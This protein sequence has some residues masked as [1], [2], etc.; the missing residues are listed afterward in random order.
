MGDTGIK[1]HSG[2][3]Q[4]NTITTFEN[5]D[6]LSITH[7]LF[8]WFVYLFIYLFIIGFEGGGGCQG[9]TSTQVTITGNHL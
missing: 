7:P 8:Y 6:V 4:K 1:I 5:V 2:F 3:L 9:Q